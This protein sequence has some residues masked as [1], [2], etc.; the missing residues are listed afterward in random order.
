[1]FDSREA[2]VEIRNRGALGAFV[3]VMNLPSP[4]LPRL[5][6]LAIPVLVTAYVLA[7][8][9]DE[10]YYESLG[11]LILS[12]IIYLRFVPASVALPAGRFLLEHPWSALVLCAIPVVMLVVAVLLGIF[13]YRKNSLLLS[14][15]ALLLTLV[16][17]TTYHYLQPLGFTVFGTDWPGY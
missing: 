2:G 5:M 8:G 14:S 10:F 6:V 15:L 4:R 7:V 12:P 13:A 16:V 9:P 3:F 11:T 17:F 1:M